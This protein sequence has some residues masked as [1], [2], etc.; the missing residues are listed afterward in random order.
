VCSETW[1][2]KAGQVYCNVRRDVGDE[3]FSMDVT[4]RMFDF[5]PKKQKADK[6]R[7]GR[8]ADKETKEEENTSDEAAND[9]HE[10]LR[11]CTGN[12]AS[13]PQ[14]MDVK[15]AEFSMAVGGKELIKSTAL[16]FTAGKR[17]GLV[18]LN[19]C[20]KS[21]FLHCVA[22]RE[23]PI[24][25]HLDIY[26]LQEEAEPSEQTALQAVIAHVERETARL[27][28]LEESIMMEC[29]PDDPRLPAIYDKLEELDP[30]G[31]EARAGELLHGLGFNKA[32]LAKGLHPVRWLTA[33]PSPNS[34]E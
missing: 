34:T 16:E 29:G 18:G 9:E 26:H 19:G 3:L 20:G 1:L 12:L 5:V 17:Y 32:M 4:D 24:P 8:K 33:T 2:V 21:N 6:E 13:Q 11:T 15:V 14:A 27:Q 23:I 28:A 30:K 22:R 31:Y 10:A 7:K 25:E